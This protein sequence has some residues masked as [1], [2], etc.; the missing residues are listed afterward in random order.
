MPSEQPAT[1]ADLK[2]AIEKVKVDFTRH[3][4]VPLAIIM[5]GG[6]GCTLMIL[7]YL[8]PSRH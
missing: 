7:L 2:E 4:V 6:F 8:L 3:M 5:A 1:K